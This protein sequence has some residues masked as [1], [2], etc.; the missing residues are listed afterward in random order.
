MWNT[1]APSTLW[2]PA[3]CWEKINL[4]PFVCLFFLELYLPHIIQNWLHLWNTWQTTDGFLETHMYTHTHTHTH[5]WGI[6]WRY[7]KWCSCPPKNDRWQRDR[8]R[9]VFSFI[10]RGSIHLPSEQNDDNAFNGS[11]SINFMNDTCTGMC[12]ETHRHTVH[13][14]IHMPQFPLP[15]PP[16]PPPPP[17]FLSASLRLPLSRKH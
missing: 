14:L 5:T 17:W 8:L 9:C 10:A 6:L 2:P 16:P 12:A 13:L 11:I 15:L 1:E 7:W 3:L 4:L